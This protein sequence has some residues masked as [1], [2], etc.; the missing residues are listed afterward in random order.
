MDPIIKGYKPLGDSES[1]NKN[2]SA[3]EDELL[4]EETV[5]EKDNFII[6][7]SGNKKAEE[8]ILKQKDYW[9]MKRKLWRLF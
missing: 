7:L 8:K 2:V 1:E 3:V 9:Q 6:K 5:C 4:E